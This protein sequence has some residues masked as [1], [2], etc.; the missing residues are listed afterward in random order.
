MANMKSVAD[1]SFIQTAESPFSI[2]IIQGIIIDYR[3][4]RKGIIYAEPFEKNM[5]IRCTGIKYIYF[6]IS[7]IIGLTL[8]LAVKPQLSMSAGWPFRNFCSIVEFI[9]N[10]PFVEYR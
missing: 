10:L 7:M 8:Q 3:P 4:P 1:L 6:L 2:I 5:A 9:C